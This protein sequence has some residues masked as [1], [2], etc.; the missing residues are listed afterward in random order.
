[1]TVSAST[2]LYSGFIFC[3]SLTDLLGDIDMESIRHQ[4][5]ILLHSVP[6]FPVRPA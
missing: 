5:N 1:M 3:V 2:R 6:T 4:V